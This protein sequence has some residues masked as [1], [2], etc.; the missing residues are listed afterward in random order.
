MYFPYLRSK[1]E[2]V[3]AVLEADLAGNL[4]IPIFEPVQTLF[5]RNGTPAITF[6]RL[7]EATEKG[8]RFALITN[9]ANGPDRPSVD[10]VHTAIDGLSDDAVFPAFEIR[11]DTDLS[12]AQ[13]FAERFVGRTCIVVHR[14]HVYSAQELGEVLAAL[15]EPVQVLVDGEAARRVVFDLPAC[16][17]V[18]VSDGFDRQPRNADY[19]RRTN[20][21]DL[22]HRLDDVDCDFDG[23][24]DFVIVGRRFMMGGGRANNIALHLTE[25]T[26]S[27][28]I[29]HHF[30][31]RTAPNAPQRQMYFD[32]LAQLMEGVSGKEGF[33]TAGV[34]AFRD[35]SVRGHYPGLGSPKRWS[36]MHHLEI[37]E[38]ALRERDAQPIL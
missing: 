27:T 29:A 19:P 21:D 16:K 4:T 30:V 23:F 37:I 2:E 33:N 25:V 26:Q 1:R 3:L 9:S 6:T 31:S 35:T 18:L 34:A 24:G 13:S 14:N 17:R 12:D 36:I 8:R 5:N 38:G 15:G 28:V 11:G 22:L 20:F 32:A 7:K 10:H